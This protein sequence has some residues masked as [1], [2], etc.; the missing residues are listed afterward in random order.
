MGSAGVGQLTVCEKGG[1]SEEV[2]ED[3]RERAFDAFR[4]DLE[5][6]KGPFPCTFGVAA[7]K[8]DGLRYAFVEDP[9]DSRPSGFG[10]R[11]PTT[12]GATAAS[13]D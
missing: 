10:V 4:A 13:G 12:W 6:A 11:W 2:E 5:G 7:L 8:R 9:R 1:T 3:W